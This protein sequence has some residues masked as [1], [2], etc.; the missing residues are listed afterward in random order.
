MLPVPVD[1]A[2]ETYTRGENTDLYFLEADETK[3]GASRQQ[4]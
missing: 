2:T 4:L 1:Y 3:Q